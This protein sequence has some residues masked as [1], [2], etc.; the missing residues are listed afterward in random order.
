MASADEY[1][2][3]PDILEWRDV[4]VTVDLS[5]FIPN[6]T[7][8]ELMVMGN[9]T[10]ILGGLI[11]GGLIATFTGTIDTASDSMT[12]RV[13]HAG[14]WNPFPFLGTFFVTPRGDGNAGFNVNGTYISVSAVVQW[15]EPV[16]I[17]GVLQFV[18]SPYA[19][20]QG[21]SR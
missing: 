6:V 14:G 4:L 20:G 21:C 8:P 11:D 10:L 18:G 12:A 9:G 7:E 5:P 13:Y 19:A 16:G 1:V 2:M 3:I 17:A 15:L